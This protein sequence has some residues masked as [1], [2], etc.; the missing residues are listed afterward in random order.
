MFGAFQHPAGI[1]IRRLWLSGCLQW[2]ALKAPWPELQMPIGMMQAYE[3]P[4]IIS[5]LV[6]RKVAVNHRRSCRQSG[7]KST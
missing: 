2:G 6:A 5:E 7:T 1:P 3:V 4:G